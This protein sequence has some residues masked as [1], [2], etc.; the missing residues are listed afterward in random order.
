MM[1][2]AV[3]FHH[4]QQ[5]VRPEYAKTAR[6][7]SRPR[8][9]GRPSNYRPR[10]RHQGRPSVTDPEV[11]LKD[12][13][14]DLPYSKAPHQGSDGGN[15]APDEIPQHGSDGGNEAPDEIPHQVIDNGRVP[16]KRMKGGNSNP[17]G[18]RMMK[19]HKAVYEDGM[20]PPRNLL[21]GQD[22]GTPLF[23]SF[24]PSPDA[25]VEDRTLM[26]EPDWSLPPA[27]AGASTRPPRRPPLRLVAPLPWAG[28]CR[29]LLQ[30]TRRRSAYV[31]V[32]Y[33][34][35]FTCS[36]NGECTGLR[37]SVVHSASKTG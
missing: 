31:R 1:I 13:E 32:F 2:R 37:P 22:D 20:V 19:M 30:T 4:H 8:H 16:R 27:V 23:N 6:S 28:S 12:L 10:G 3:P 34:K 5:P 24:L 21:G 25:S 7:T 33:V 14:V 35:R 11:D 26:N 18:C 17:R 15:E 29:C 36:Y 9:Q